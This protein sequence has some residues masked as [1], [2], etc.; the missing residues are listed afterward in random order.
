MISIPL[1]Q[2]KNH[3]SELLDRVEHGE[4]IVVTRRGKTVA[5]LAPAG[6]APP[7]DAQRSRVQHVFRQLSA[8]C[9]GIHL[10][11]DLKAI[12]REGLD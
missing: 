1:A 9:G 8:L 2:A 3:L 6:D 5:H 4:T 7:N 12:A 11:G 10:E